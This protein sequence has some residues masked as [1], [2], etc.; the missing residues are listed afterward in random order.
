ML[1]E[2]KDDKISAVDAGVTRVD[3]SD[4]GFGTQEQVETQHLR[5][6][7]S[8]PTFYRSVLLQMILLGA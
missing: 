6:W 1:P 3:S 2:Q 4:V 7:T 5:S 8:W